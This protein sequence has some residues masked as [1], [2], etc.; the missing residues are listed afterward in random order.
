MVLGWVYA[1]KIPMFKIIID[2]EYVND[3]DLQEQ[4]RKL[5]PHFA[6]WPCQEGKE[7]YIMLS[8]NPDKKE[9]MDCRHWWQSDSKEIESILRKVLYDQ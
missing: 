1:N 7:G 3:P 8:H 9:I 6:N 4:K 2:P 5:E